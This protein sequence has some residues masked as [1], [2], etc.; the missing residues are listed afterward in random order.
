MR[1]MLAQ[2][3]YAKMEIQSILSENKDNLIQVMGPEFYTAF[4]KNKYI[5]K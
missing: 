3:K 2:K 4:R 1:T 5:R